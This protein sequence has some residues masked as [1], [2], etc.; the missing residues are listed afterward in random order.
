VIIDKKVSKLATTRNKIKRRIR[1][2]LKKSD[3]QTGSIIIRGYAGVEK[4][5]F[6][7][8]VVS[9]SKVLVRIKR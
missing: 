1:E 2:I 5:S 6:E 7:E 4:M 8:L 9:C 3:L